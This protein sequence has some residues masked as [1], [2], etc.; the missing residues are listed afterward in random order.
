MKI[1]NFFL[2]TMFLLTFYLIYCIIID[3]SDLIFSYSYEDKIKFPKSKS[4]NNVQNQIKLCLCKVFKNYKIHNM[5]RIWPQHELIIAGWRVSGKVVSGC[6]ASWSVVG[7]S[8]G[9]GGFN[10]IPKSGLLD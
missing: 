2:E 8:A 7:R 4:Q 9:G 3:F 10:K 1:V 6:W 5:F